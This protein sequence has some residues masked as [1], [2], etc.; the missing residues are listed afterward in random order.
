ML[1]LAGNI[2][3]LVLGIFWH[4]LEVRFIQG[5]LAHSVVGFCSAQVL[6]TTSTL[7]MGVNLPAHLVVVKGTKRYV[8][9][10]ET[11]PGETTGY[12]EYTQTEVG[13]LTRGFARGLVSSAFTLFPQCGTGGSICQQA[14]QPLKQQLIQTV[15]FA[16]CVLM[17]VLQMVG[18]AGRPQFDNEGVAVIMTSKD[19]THS[20]QRMMTGQVSK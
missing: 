3:M 16:D 1:V 18:R 15:L 8:G 6:C 5:M 11:A 7:A 17:Q 14:F 10:S 4:A 12:K 19:S 13:Y 2:L 9:E 20:Y